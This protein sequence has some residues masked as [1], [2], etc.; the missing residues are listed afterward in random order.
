MAGPVRLSRHAWQDRF[1]KPTIE[2]LQAPYHGVAAQLFEDARQRLRAVDFLTERLLWQGIPWRWTL[3]YEGGGDADRPWAYIIPHPEKP[4]IALPLIE[5]VVAWL[6]W[7][8]LKRYIRDGIEG[9]RQVNGVRWAVYEL[10]NR[11]N[12]E[13]VFD[14]LRRKERYFAALGA[15]DDQA[16]SGAA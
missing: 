3:T 14:L 7:K 8:R 13:D 10:S 6:P 1:R 11:T 5:A 2:A 15:E 12:L 16:M 9:A 4:L